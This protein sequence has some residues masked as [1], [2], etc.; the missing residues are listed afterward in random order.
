MDSA[1]QYLRSGHKKVEGWLDV[2]S[3]RYIFEL[4]KL[5]NESGKG[6]AAV[7]IGVH[8]GKL[9]TLMHLAGSRTRDLAIDV[10]DFQNF[11]TDRSGRGDRARFEENLTNYGG[12]LEKVTIWEKSSQSVTGEDIIAEVGQVAMFSVDGGHTRELVLNDLKLADASLRD[13]GIVILDDF[14]NEYWPEV[15][16]GSVEYFNDPASRLK[17]F[18]ISPGKMYLCAPQWN[19][20]Y[21]EN[22]RKRVAPWEYDKDVEM[23]GV[24]VQLMGTA[25]WKKSAL[26]RALWRV[27]D[28]IK[29]S[30]VG[31]LFK[32]AA[33]K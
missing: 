1:S 18:A 26:N 8:H 12:D 5:Q 21:R 17:P 13:D 20:F 10:F 15:S 11:N 23:F 31:F 16:I 24:T 22:L 19:A 6:G 30:P 4:A 7:E 28:A 27:K 32:R 14:F 33:G 3:A 29:A 25:T 9:F 2:S